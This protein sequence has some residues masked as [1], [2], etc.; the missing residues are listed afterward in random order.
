M[1]AQFSLVK[2]FLLVSQMSSKISEVSCVIRGTTIRFIGSYKI[3]EFTYS[4]MAGLGIHIK[5]ALIL[6]FTSM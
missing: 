3:T 4:A 6:L 1:H 2:A 5:N